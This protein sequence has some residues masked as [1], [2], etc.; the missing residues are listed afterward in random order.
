MRGHDIQQ[1]KVFS[2]QGVE[3]LQKRAL[4]AQYVEI[5]AGYLLYIVG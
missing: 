5:V 2:Y 1:Q 3:K 4:I